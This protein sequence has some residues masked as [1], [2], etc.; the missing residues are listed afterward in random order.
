[1]FP[2]VMWRDTVERQGFKLIVIGVATTFWW[3]VWHMSNILISPLSFDDGHLQ[4]N[5]TGLQFFFIRR[6]AIVCYSFESW[7]HY[8]ALPTSMSVYSLTGCSRH[9]THCCLMPNW[10]FDK[11]ATF[12]VLLLLYCQQGRSHADSPS[13][14]SRLSNIKTFVLKSFD[15][16][17]YTL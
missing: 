14:W 11:N 2:S 7:S 9:S 10:I 15:T 5:G 16:Y 3:H 13:E 12:S 4:P 1:M 6:V 8:H 17:L